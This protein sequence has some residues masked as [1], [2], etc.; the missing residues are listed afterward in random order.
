MTAGWFKWGVLPWKWCWNLRPE[1]APLG[2][3]GSHRAYALPESGLSEPK[4]LLTVLFT[5]TFSLQISV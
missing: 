2:A 1:A 5:P 4:S 3:W